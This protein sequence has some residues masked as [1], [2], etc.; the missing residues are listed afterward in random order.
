M[1]VIFLDRDG[2]I[3]IFTPNDYI[4]KWEEFR[5]LPHSRAG[6]KRLN[7]AGYE[8]VV[9]SNQAGVNKGL[10]SQ[11]DLQDVTARMLRVL[12]KDG[13]RIAKVYYCIHTKEENCNCRKPRTGLFAKA[14]K[15][16][17][18]R[19]LAGSF[20]IGDSQTDVEAGEAAGTRT[21]LVFSGKTR[22]KKE[23]RDWPV[24]PDFTARNLKEAVDIVLNKRGNNGKI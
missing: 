11:A 22:N 8:I 16:L 3:S 17:G 13:I 21:I 12:K 4:K 19:S 1:K 20:F 10:F 7:R 15:E 23:I 18:L 5:F 2:V 9:I 14:Q 6:L 24:K